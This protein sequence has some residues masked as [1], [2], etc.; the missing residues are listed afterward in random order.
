MPTTAKQENARK[1][2]LRRARAS[3]VSMGA[4]STSTA[5]MVDTNGDVRSYDPVVVI[6]NL[7]ADLAAEVD[8]LA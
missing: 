3:L 4:L 1:D 2:A 5:Q 7:V 8:T 6:A